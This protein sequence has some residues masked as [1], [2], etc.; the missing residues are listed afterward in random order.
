MVA[1]FGCGC[2]TLGLAAALLGA[3]SVNLFRVQRHLYPN[4]W[5][6]FLCLILFVMDRHVMGL[7]IDAE[8]LEVA[9][10]NAVEL[11]VLDFSCVY[12]CYSLF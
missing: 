4:V 2:G 3:E 8:S 10:E 1:D 5:S 9:C 12:C 7:D 11:E 6:W